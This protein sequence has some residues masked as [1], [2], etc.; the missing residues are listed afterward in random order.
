[1]GKR[2]ARPGIE[3]A[4]MVKDGESKSCK[5]FC[6]YVAYILMIFADVNLWK[7]GPDQ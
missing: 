2:R 5:D 3:V 7:L 1:M 6:S 4:K